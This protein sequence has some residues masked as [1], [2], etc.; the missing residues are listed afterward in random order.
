MKKDRELKILENADNKT[1]E[2]LADVSPLTKSEKERILAMSKD[3][4]YNMKREH[5]IEEQVTGVER[6]SKPK[7]QRFTAIAAS[8]LLVGGI[9]GTALLLNINGKPDPEDNFSKAGYS[10]ST[11]TDA[12]KKNNPSET[13]TVAP[14]FDGKA[15]LETLFSELNVLNN[16]CEGS[17]VEIDADSLISVEFDGEM[18]DYHYVTDSR[19]KTKDEAWEFFGKT[20]AQP[21][22][23]SFYPCFNDDF[24]PS[25]FFESDGKLYY[26]AKDDT[27]QS[28]VSDVGTPEITNYSENSFDYSVPAKVGGISSIIKG[29][30]VKEDGKWKISE[31]SFDITPELEKSEEKTSEPIDEGAAT[32]ETAEN[33]K[34]KIQTIDIIASGSGVGIDEAFSEYDYDNGAYPAKYNRVSD[35]RFKSLAE[36][37]SFFKESFTDS[38]LSSYQYL[39]S[40]N[41]S[42]AAMF[43][44]FDGKLYYIETGRGARYVYISNPRITSNS[45]DSFVFEADNELPGGEKEL[46]TVSC[47]KENGKWKV[48]SITNSEIPSQTD[49]SQLEDMKN[50]ANE[51]LGEYHELYLI[52][53]GSSVDIDINDSKTVDVEEGLSKT[54]YKVTDSR[55]PTLDS[56]EAYASDIAANPLLGNISYTALSQGYPTP[57]FKDFDGTLYFG[58]RSDTYNSNI[59]YSGQPE[60]SSASDDRFNFSVQAS[61]GGIQYTMN[62]TVIMNNGKWKISD[63]RLYNEE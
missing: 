50:A 29:K 53:G 12:D 63:Y 59:I 14:D 55:F 58:Y 47:V 42:N 31:Y 13:T 38:F 10:T 56:V 32:A 27:T 2:R 1:V 39:W 35:N 48:D 17:G 26:F 23:A 7:W 15:T 34:L 16:I 41:D 6:Y 4:L 5:N 24:S 30:A 57:T 43:R 62:G 40:G 20:L 60:I 49:S 33:L 22:L 54:Y 51:L 21:A 61:I 37:Q 8:F 3:K 25:V 52:F 9:V 19:F 44:E 18:C 11:S 45:S 28:D 36:V 46:V